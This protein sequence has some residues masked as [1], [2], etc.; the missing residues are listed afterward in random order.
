[1]PK[2]STTIKPGADR[3]LCDLKRVS[4]AKLGEVFFELRRIF[5]ELWK[6]KPE[7]K[8]FETQGFEDRKIVELKEI[9]DN[10]AT[11]P[12]CILG[13]NEVLDGRAW[14]GNDGD[15]GVSHYV[16]FDFII[17]LEATLRRLLFSSRT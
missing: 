2:I 16:T 15:G 14:A 5:F 13:G 8:H 11:D 9:V 12:N 1:M 7:N 6:S 4:A 10:A 3:E 17:L